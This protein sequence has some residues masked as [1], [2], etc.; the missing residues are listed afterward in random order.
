MEAPQLCCLSL[1]QFESRIMTNLN[2]LQVEKN[3]CDMT[4]ACEDQQIEVI[5]AGGSL[6]F[7]NTSN[8]MRSALPL[9][10][11]LAAVDCFAHLL[12][13]TRMGASPIYFHAHP[14]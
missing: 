1:K 9:L 14:S 5:L 2:Q 8:Q 6:L 11:L 3:F 10:G 7:K 13:T 4:I 12:C